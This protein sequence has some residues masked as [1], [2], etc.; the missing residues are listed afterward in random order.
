MEAKISRHRRVIQFLR[1]RYLWLPRYLAFMWMI[2]HL[3]KEMYRRQEHLGDPKSPYPP[4]NLALCE[5]DI[6]LL[7]RGRQEVSL[8]GTYAV[9]HK[10]VENHFSYTVELILTFPPLK[11][12]PPTSLPDDIFWWKSQYGW[13]KHVNHRN[14]I[15]LERARGPKIGMKL[16]AAI[17]SKSGFKLSFST[18]F[19][20]C[21]RTASR[22]NNWSL[23]NC[24]VLL[25]LIV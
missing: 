17:L 5:Q 19:S 14:H 1:P 21:S 25:S 13:Q 15:M 20:V 22:S 7:S 23:G 24:F 16:N 8:W 6:S 12:F 10:M 2:T 9:I 11:G 18:P 4:K 3:I